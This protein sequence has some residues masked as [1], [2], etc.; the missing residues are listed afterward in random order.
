MHF[1][2]IF[3]DEEKLVALNPVFESRGLKLQRSQPYAWKLFDETD[4]VPVQHRQYTSFRYPSCDVF[5]MKV[6]HVLGKYL[7]KGPYKGYL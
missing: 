1:A 3:Q 6:S 4:S 2:Y 7:Y 5:L